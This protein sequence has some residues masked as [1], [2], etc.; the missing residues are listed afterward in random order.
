MA[1][2]RGIVDNTDVLAGKKVIDM[3]EHLHLLEDKSKDAMTRMLMKLP[4]RP[5]KNSTIFW[6]T[7]SIA[8]KLDTLNEDVDGTE[9]AVDVTDGTVWRIND[10]LKVPGTGETM[11]VTGISTNTL[12]VTRSWGA[13]AAAST[14]LSGDQIINLGGAWSEGAHLRTSDS[15]DAILLRRTTE[16][17][18]SSYTQIFREPFGVT[19]T[20]KQTRVYAGDVYD[21][22][23]QEALLVILRDME[24]SLFHGEEAEST[25]RR[26]LGG[27][28]E[29]LGAADF[30]TAALTEGQF[31]TDLATAFVDG[32]STK[33]L[34]CSQQVAGYISEWAQQVQRVAP[35]DNKFGVHITKYTSPH[36]NVDIVVTY[37][38]QGFTVYNKYAALVDMDEVAL[39]PLQDLV[40]LTDRE[41]N[42]LDGDLGEY[43]C[44]TGVEWGH[45]GKSAWWDSITS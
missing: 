27:L 5:A 9:T 10:I 18:N 43:L 33:T 1:I 22:D 19:R 11:L 32:S 35:G 29:F 25:T 26:T 38:F 23:K 3:S 8:P 20:M 34:F 28:L 41:S 42:D 21:R 4:K 37:A 12:T 16:V 17:S 7:K 39:R 45:G 13:T 40:M 2:T 6:M 31:N 36:G 15:D 14:A 44:E 24:D 30:S